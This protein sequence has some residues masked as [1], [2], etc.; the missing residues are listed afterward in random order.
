MR[1][2][3][4]Q[5]ITKVSILT[6][7]RLLYLNHSRQRQKKAAPKSCLVYACAWRIHKIT[8]QSA[9]GTTRDSVCH[10]YEAKLSGDLGPPD[11]GNRPANPACIRSS[12]QY[13]E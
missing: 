6:K 7:R 8:R 3:S 11:S 4:I 2:L 5:I 10:R 1:R 9:S 13:R 12:L